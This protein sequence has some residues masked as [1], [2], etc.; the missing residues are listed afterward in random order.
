MR[1]TFFSARLA[2]AAASLF[3]S[4]A[5][6]ESRLPAD[7]VPVFQQVHLRTDADS[8]SYSGWIKVDLDVRKPTKSI[9][10][11]AQGQSLGRMTLT[12]SGKSIAVRQSPSGDQLV[13]TASRQLAKGPA[14]LEIHFV[15]PY[16]TQA[17]GLYRVKRGDQG[18]LFTQFEATD[19]RQAFPCW[20][21]PSF[22]FPY[23]ITL[24]IPESQQAVTNTPI[25]KE[26]SAKGWKTIAF[27]K[28]P[29]MP[30][31]LLAM[32]VG[33]LE[34]VEVPGTKFPT[35]VVTV[36]GQSHLAQLAV[37]A[38]PPVIAALEAYFEMPY[39]YAKLDLIAVPEYW[40]GAMENP[41]A[42]TFT[43]SAL[44]LDPA[45]ASMQ[46]RRTLTRYLAH[47]LAHMWFG[48]FVTM[49]WWDDLWLNESFADWMGDKIS[50]QV[51]PQFQ[52]Q[53]GE[54]STVQNIMEVDARPTTDPVRN[55]N[56]SGNDAMRSVGLAYYKGKAVLGMFE[57]WI[58]PEVFRQ[59][60]NEYLR[61]HAWKNAV[62]SD[63][64][65][66]LGKVSGKDVPAAMAGYIEQQG[67]PLLTVELA[68]NGRIRF[69]QKRFL[70]HGVKAD[71]LLWKIPVAFKWSDGSKV[72]TQRVFLD[73]PSTT[74]DLE[75]GGKPVWV[76]PNVDG[77]GY[78]RWAAP[79]SMMLAL[80][81]NAVAGMNAGERIAFIGNA[82]AL[83][84]AGELRG[85]AYLR[86]LAAF[87]DDPDPL[88]AS[89]VLDGLASAKTNFIPDD[90]REVFAVY[91][92]Q[93]LKPMAKRFGL[94]KKE[95]EPEVVSLLRPQLFDWLGDEGQDSGALGLA[96]RISSQ[97]MKDPGASDPS[98]VGT[99][100]QLHAIRG[101]RAL[102]ERYR[103]GFEEAKTPAARQRYLGAL[104]RFHDPALQDEA[105]RYALEG[106]VRV[107]EIRTITG[108]IRAQSD[109]A[110]DRAFTWL[111]Q[112]WAEVTA[113]IPEEFQA[114]LPGYANGCSE[115][116]ITIAQQFFSEPAHKV[117]GTE[118]ELSEVVEEV[119]DCVELRAREGSS[120]AGYL[121]TLPGGNAAARPASSG[122]P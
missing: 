66:A 17:V 48:D 64:W 63:L 116:R 107:N 76:M 54:I 99:A 74:V 100:L 51:A 60:V 11:H 110:H 24:E 117:A 103:K 113:K 3:V 97:Y 12:Q 78:Y 29:P 72:H 14:K 50:E 68:E 118:K 67:L 53:L 85:D 42:I 104:G 65:T 31:Y 106:P 38:T 62:A 45:S 95:G 23:Q 114:S 4:A 25:E 96:E 121:R 10:L 57:H 8:S 90:L 112:H 84:Q 20:D 1:P 18:Y 122:S 71:P 46:S 43:E 56:A 105:L 88:V 82:Q 52:L 89:A 59:G 109:R 93:T 58:G 92:R 39:P 98:M 27:Q 15:R 79:Q 81:R 102:F 80:S 30:S 34:F 101:D 2:A 47:E 49:A 108:G 33:R 77:R 16:S 61:A 19:A 111:R 9:T 7:V 94:E 91:V 41:G 73:G 21:E 36:K 5:L 32:A 120:V 26:T 70:H 13:L 119:Q 37:Q 35:R 115:E 40:F 69:G 22:K 86:L 87:S 28:T 6:A 83:L 55:P 75:G 44:L